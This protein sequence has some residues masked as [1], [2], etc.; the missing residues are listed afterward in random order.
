MPLIPDDP[1]ALWAELTTL[2]AVQAAYQPFQVWRQ[3]RTGRLHAWLVLL[4]HHAEA[5]Q[6]AAV[7][8]TTCEDEMAALAVIF[9]CEDTPCDVTLVRTQAAFDAALHT[10]GIIALLGAAYTDG[11]EASML[12]GPV[13][14][15]ARV[16][17]WLV[18]PNAAR[19][20]AVLNEY[21]QEGGDDDG[22][23]LASG[24]SG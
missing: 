21:L 8:R 13:T 11:I 7:P 9:A 18:S 10:G 5:A 16:S 19:I 6:V 1:S 17:T 4:G 24:V 15:R 22:P 23:T 12:S 2:A 20:A 14:A 3:F